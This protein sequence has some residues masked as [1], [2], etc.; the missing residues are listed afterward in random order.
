MGGLGNQI[1]QIFATISYSIRTRNEFKFLNLDVLSDGTCTPRNT[2]WKSFFCNLRPFLVDK[3]SSDLIVIKENNFHYNDIPLYYILNRNIMLCGYYQSY[4][5]FHQN[6]DLICKVIGL[7]KTKLNLI[8]KLNDRKIHYNFKDL[9][10]IH[11]R[12][13]DYIK[14]QDF[15]P[16]MTVEYYKRSLKHIKLNNPEV[17]YTILY[18]CEDIDTE[19]VLKKIDKLREEFNDY[20]FIRGNNDLADWEQM[21]LMS[22]CHHNII[23]N[24]SFSWWAAYFND[25]SDKI[26][27]Y[28][29]LWFG[30]KAGN[31]TK[32]LCPPEWIKINA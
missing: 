31:N 5:Y 11:F 23:A 7:N 16:I 14:V 12:I 17:K 19:D 3:S 4:K 29:S 15:H 30:E 22:S 25:W 26:V 27:C 6:Y 18:F 28:P 1:F 9:I 8:K 13:G 2:Y 20:D 32:D 10:S 24:S 21:L